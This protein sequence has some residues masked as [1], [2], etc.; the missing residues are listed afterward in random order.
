MNT[1]IA[2]LL[3]GWLT[4]MTLAALGIVATLLADWRRRR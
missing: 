4:L 2:I 1:S 3:A